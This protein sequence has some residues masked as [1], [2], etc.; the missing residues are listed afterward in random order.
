MA[1]G[2]QTWNGTWADLVAAPR[3]MRIAAPAAVEPDT[4]WSPVVLAILIC[5]PLLVFAS[6]VFPGP[7]KINTVLVRGVNDGEIL[8]FARLARRPDHEVRFIEFMPL[9]AQS[10][11]DAGRVVTGREPPR[12]QW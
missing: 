3:R 2:N 4:G 11:W 5:A 1:P 7:L 10:E 12:S 6:E 8:D 9:D